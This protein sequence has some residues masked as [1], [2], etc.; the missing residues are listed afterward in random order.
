MRQRLPNSLRDGGGYDDGWH[1]HHWLHCNLPALSPGNQPGQ[2]GEAL[3][4]DLSDHWTRGTSDGGRHQQYDLHEGR[5]DGEPEAAT[6]CVGDQQNIQEGRGDQGISVSLRAN[7][8]KFP[9]ISAAGYQPE[10][11]WPGWDLSPP[12]TRKTS[13]T[14]ISFI[15]RDF[16]GATRIVMLLTPLRT[17]LLA[18][19]QGKSFVK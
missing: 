19:E 6:G 13:R 18:M 7:N 14:R 17:F 9:L 3:P 5:P 4:R 16:S 1:R 10:P 8:N 15:L 11:P 2:T 12:W